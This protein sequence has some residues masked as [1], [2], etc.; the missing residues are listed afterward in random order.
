MVNKY[1]VI[2]KKVLHYLCNV[3]LKSINP[4][5]GVYYVTYINHNYGCLYKTSQSGGYEA[6]DLIPDTKLGWLIYG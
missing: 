5:N 2:N 3:K 1:T 4:I 6:K